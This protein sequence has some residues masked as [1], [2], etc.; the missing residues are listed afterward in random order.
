ME[1][2]AVHSTYFDSDF[3]SGNSFTSFTPVLSEA[4]SSRWRLKT[5][6]KYGHKWAFHFYK[7]VHGELDSRS[8]DPGFQVAFHRFPDLVF[9]QE[10]GNGLDVEVMRSVFGVRSV[11]KW[12]NVK[13]GTAWLWWLL[14][15]QLGAEI[16]NHFVCGTISGAESL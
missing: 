4:S 8:H 6:C 11:K 12:N 2:H 5:N 1:E 3:E 15:R 9:P 7:S 10:G 13:S 16:V 14:D